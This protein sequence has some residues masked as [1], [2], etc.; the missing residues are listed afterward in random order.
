MILGSQSVDDASAEIEDDPRE[1][2]NSSLSQA[3]TSQP[4]AN[5]TISGSRD[6]TKIREKHSTKVE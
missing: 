4:R 5:F 1:E 2:S 3:N 6:P